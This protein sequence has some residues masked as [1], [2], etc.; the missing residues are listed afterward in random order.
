V[1]DIEDYRKEL[2]IRGLNLIMKAVVIAG[3]YN[4][5]GIGDLD[6]DIDGVGAM[7]HSTRLAVETLVCFRP[8][9]PGDQYPK[10]E[11]TEYDLLEIADKLFDEHE[12]R[13]NALKR[14]RVKVMTED[15]F[16]KYIQSLPRIGTR[17]KDD[18]FLYPNSEEPW[19]R[20]DEAQIIT[21]D[22]AWKEGRYC[23][24]A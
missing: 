14:D 6:D 20:D 19:E 11:Y 12:A 15:E 23:R 2:V 9:E 10:T 17:T 4:Y 8:G 21:A 13:L 24:K 18:K 7:Y 1:K 5:V 22:E 16:D 3:E